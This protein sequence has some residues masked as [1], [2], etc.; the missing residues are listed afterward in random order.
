[1]EVEYTGGP[2]GRIQDFATG[3]GGGALASVGVGCGGG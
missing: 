3:G 2:Q 1:M